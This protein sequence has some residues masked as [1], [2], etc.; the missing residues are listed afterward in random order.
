M[1]KKLIYTAVVFSCLSLL[2]C[3]KEL[4]KDPIGLIT[5]GQVTATPTVNTIASS[6]DGSYQMLSNTLNLIGRWAWAQGTVVR[7]DFVLHDLA[8]GDMQK[9]WALDGDQPW[10]DEVAGFKF[11]SN[12]GA[13]N[14]IWSFDYEGISRA[15]QAIQY[16]TD[17]NLLSGLNMA[18]ALRNR[19]LAEVLFLRSFYYFDLVNNFGDVPLVLEPLTSFSDAYAAANR[20]P[21]DQILTQISKDLAEAK[22]LMPQS[23]YSNESEKWR[24]SLGAVIALQA[25]MALY[26][27]KWAETVSLIDEL[28]RLGYYKLNSNYFDSFSVSKEFA[29][30]EVIFAHDHRMGKLPKSGNGLAALLGWGFVAPTQDFIQAFEPNDPRLPYTVNIQTKSVNKLLGTLDGTYKGNDDAPNN[31]I[32]IRYADVLL[33]KAEAFIELDDLDK[34]VAIINTVRDRARNTATYDGSS[35]PA[36][37][38]PQRDLA[39]ADKQKVKEWLI[40]ERRVELGFESQRFNDLKRWK[41][42]SQVLTALGKNFQDRNYLYPIPQAEIDKS[43]GAIVQNPGYN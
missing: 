14:G 16:L 11:T 24:A 4:Y 1:Q 28:E 15:N 38:L 33:W 25:K 5:P 27:K 13:F 30:S 35:L 3:K 22:K 20:V 31:K 37:T 10:M 8:S 23:K 12:N 9:K 34:A 21:V 26:Q 2:G 36:G 18:E 39:S 17:Q 41:L 32:Y 42:A 19:Y 40:H 43:G 6:V 29:D 7:P